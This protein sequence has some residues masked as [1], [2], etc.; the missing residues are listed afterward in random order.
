MIQ[1]TTKTKKAHK[2]K[3]TLDANVEQPAANVEQPAINV[4]QP[5]TNVES[6]TQASGLDKYYDWDDETLEAFMSNDKVKRMIPKNKVKKNDDLTCARSK[7]DKLRKLK[8]RDIVGPGK[9]PDD[10]LVIIEEETTVYVLGGA[11]TSK[12]WADIRK[13]LTR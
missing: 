10:P 9:E 13:G 11:K 4:E 6:A 12:S 2:K 8:T 1:A 3:K 7:S 5:S